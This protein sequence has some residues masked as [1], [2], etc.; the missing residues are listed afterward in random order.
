MKIKICGMRRPED[1]AYA[2]E[3]RPDYVGFILAEGFRRTISEE[4]AKALKKDLHP[5]IRAVGVFVND[6]VERIISLLEDGT[7]DLAQLHGNESEEDIVYIKA[8]T[9]K[10]VIKVVKAENRYV[11]EAWLDTAA[12][13]LLFDS[14]TGS[15]VSFD[16]S[17]L[18]DVQRE[19]FLAG[20]L[21]S[22]KIPQAY[23]MVQ[24]YA[25]DLSSGVE[26]DGKKDLEKM[27]A[28]VKAAKSL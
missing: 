6:P 25:M 2:N 22:E 1:I 27:W 3:V 19:Y 14:G 21:D 4:T 26:T 15:G 20:G 17:I 12:D 7:I 18:Q 23:Q 11:V 8:A 16:W 9:G 24:P 28:A 13:Y 5:D 10:P